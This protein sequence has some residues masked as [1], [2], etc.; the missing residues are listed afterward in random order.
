MNQMPK[1]N[2]K[3]MIKKQQKNKHRA[4]KRGIRYSK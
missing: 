2:K 3:I 1:Q 4:I